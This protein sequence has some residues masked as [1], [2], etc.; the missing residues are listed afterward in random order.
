MGLQT[1]ERRAIKKARVPRVRT[2]QPT[3]QG[4]R[5]E[6]DFKMH[7]P[8]KRVSMCVCARVCIYVCMCVC[9]RGQINE[10]KQKPRTQNSR[11]IFLR[12]R[13]T[14]SYDPFD[15]LSRDCSNTFLEKCMRSRERGVPSCATKSPWSLDFSNFLAGRLSSSC[16]VLCKDTS[17]S[18]SQVN[19]TRLT[20]HG[21]RT[22]DGC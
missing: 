2:Q 5:L 4:R 9:V 14:S 21:G 19:N 8:C 16:L 17:R 22:H 18:G 3:L 15:S 20:P 12:K 10:G 11:K 1:H 7:F 13:K 6:N